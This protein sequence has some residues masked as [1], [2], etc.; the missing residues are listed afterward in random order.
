MMQ[1]F[2]SAVTLTIRSAALAQTNR[3]VSDTNTTG[4][5]RY[6]LHVG[7]QLNQTQIIIFFNAL[8]LTNKDSMQKS[9]KILP[10]IVKVRK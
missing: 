9:G 5:R 2:R 7:I 1:N 6:P 10:P 4:V 3:P 8:R